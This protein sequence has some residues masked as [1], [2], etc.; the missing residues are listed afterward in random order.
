MGQPRMYQRVSRYPPQQAID[1]AYPD[2]WCERWQWC[3]TGARWLLYCARRC[4][5]SRS[6]VQTETL[7][8]IKNIL[9]PWT[10][11][12]TN[13]KRFWWR[14][15]NDNDRP[16]AG[17]VYETYKYIK[18]VFRRRTRQC[19]D[20]SVNNKYQKLNAMLKNRKLSAF[21]N[22]IKQRKSTKVNLCVPQILMN[23]MVMLCK[24][25][26]NLLLNKPMINIR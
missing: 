14:L 22:V 6:R 26:Q 1:F 12:P 5:R 9:V 17:A 23:S 25:Y 10:Q 21:W 15:W 19:V 16:R 7:Q 13:R 8:Q 20:R 3:R 18:K 2:V 11:P 4:D 24:L